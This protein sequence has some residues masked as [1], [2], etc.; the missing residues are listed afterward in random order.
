MVPK[1]DSKEKR[2]IIDYCPLNA[3]TRKN[4]TLLPN[5]KQCIKNLQGIE[6]FSKFDIH[7]GYNNI[8]IHEGDQWKVT[9]KTHQGLFEPKV[10]FFGMSNCYSSFE[11]SNIY[12][13]KYH[14]TMRICLY[15]LSFLISMIPSLHSCFPALLDLPV[16][17]Y[18]AVIT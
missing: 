14:L 7:W 6:L 1:K 13:V 11:L 8:H 4:V 3:V 15:Q 18:L 10:M 17:R 9:F 5:L 2:Y 12:T 16:S